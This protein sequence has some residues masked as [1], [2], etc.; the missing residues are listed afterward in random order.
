MVQF[1]D[2]NGPTVFPTLMGFARD[3]AYEIT[4]SNASLPDKDFTDPENRGF[5]VADLNRLLQLYSRLQTHLAIFLS[6]YNQRDSIQGRPNLGYA[7][8]LNT[9]ENVG[10]FSNVGSIVRYVTLSF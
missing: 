3:V 7:T 8:Y 9:P 10:Y 6:I 1:A 2:Q 4:H 5:K